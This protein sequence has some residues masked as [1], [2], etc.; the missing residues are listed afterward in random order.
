[1]SAIALSNNKRIG[2][3]PHGASPGSCP[4]CNGMAGGNS[5][6]KR[7]TPRNVGEMTYNQCLAIGIMLKNQKAAQKSAEI[8]QQ[9]YMQSV[10]QFNKTLEN[11]HNRIIEFSNMI[12]KTMPRIISAPI[13]FI[14]NNI[15]VRV[16]NI[17]INVNSVFNSV[18]QK[19][20]D[21]S[22]KLAAVYGELKAAV[23]KSISNLVGSFKKKFRTLL[24]IFGADNDNDENTKI[25]ETQKAFSLR[26]FLHNLSRKFKREEERLAEYDN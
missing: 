17:V 14:L 13:N 3:C 5:T 19:F 18:M 16:L 11:M 15:V 22:D 2:T 4:I 7:N 26:T 20:A 10:N 25:E 21:I 24:Y 12:A 1:M 23:S 8:A 9:N 6:T